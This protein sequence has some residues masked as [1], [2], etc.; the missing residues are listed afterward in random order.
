VRFGGDQVSESPERT[1]P[2]YGL[3]RPFI[4]CAALNVILANTKPEYGPSG[5]ISDSHLPLGI[6]RYPFECIAGQVRADRHRF[7]VR[8]ILALAIGDDV[9]TRRAMT[10]HME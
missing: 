8:G 7:L 9:S 5:V 6:G 1:K 3:G 4:R 10:S 2:L